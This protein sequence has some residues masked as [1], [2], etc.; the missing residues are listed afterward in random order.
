VGPEYPIGR[1]PF[2]ES[3][4]LAVFGFMPKISPLL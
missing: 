1:I 3:R 2:L 4:I